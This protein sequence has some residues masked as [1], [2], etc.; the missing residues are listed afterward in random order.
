MPSTPHTRF[1]LVRHGETDWNG[2][3][4]IQGQI[5]IDLNATGAAQA[6]ALRPG[7]TQHG[8]A[9]IYSSDL[10]RAWRTAQIATADL[11]LA[12][13]PAPTLR[14][15]HFGVLQGTTLHEASQKH[16]EVHRHHLARTLDHDYE[17]GE[18]L[19]MFAAR[20]MSGLDALAARHAGQ[21]VLAFTHGGVLDVAYRAATGRALDAPRDFPVANAA[22][23]WLERDDH[24]WRLLAWADCSH[25]T[26]ALDEILE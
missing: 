9:A 20:V 13:A 12:V 18:S 11:G 8:F 16:P 3:R 24:G 25:L 22:F 14:E 5:D 2:E 23:N 15:R 1:C 17:T 4:R 7:L 10:L 21:S 26:R 19:V 6:R